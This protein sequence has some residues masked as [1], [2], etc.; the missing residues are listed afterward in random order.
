MNRDYYV[1]VRSIFIFGAFG[2]I[3]YGNKGCL[4]GILLFFVYDLITD[5]FRRKG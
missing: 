5:I 1:A 3:F 4:W 2:Y